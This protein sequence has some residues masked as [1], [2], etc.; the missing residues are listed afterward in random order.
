MSGSGGGGGGGGGGI[1]K[2]DCATLAF[3]TA[4]ASVVKNVVSQLKKDDELDVELQ[5]KGQRIV[6]AKTKAGVIAGSITSAHL[7]SLVDCLNKGFA[8]VA[9][10]LR[11]SGATCEVEV[12]PAP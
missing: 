3:R 6:I 4:L 8:F 10:V 9:I 5:A 12:R 11:V 1:P 2:S 7:A